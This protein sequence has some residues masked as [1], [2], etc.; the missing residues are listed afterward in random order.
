M[1]WLRIY[2]EEKAK[3][4][5]TGN[6]VTEEQ[7]QKLYVY[8]NQFALVSHLFWGVHALLQANFSMIDFDF[9]EYG[10]NRFYEYL[11]RKDEFLNL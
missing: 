11:R 2:L 7:I 6:V 9:L 3:V 4:Q 10:R 8:V 1:R 5:G